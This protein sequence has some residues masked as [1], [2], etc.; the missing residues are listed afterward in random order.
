MRRSYFDLSKEWADPGHNQ[1]V[2]LCPRL[3]LHNKYKFYF[4]FTLPFYWFSAIQLLSIIQLLRCIGLFCQ[5]FSKVILDSTHSWHGKVFICN[6]KTICNAILMCVGLHKIILTL[7]FN[8]IHILGLGCMKL[9][10]GG[11]KGS[12]KKNASIYLTHLVTQK[13]AWHVIGLVRSNYQRARNCSYQSSSWG[14]LE[15]RNY[16]LH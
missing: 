9:V 6:V 5:F 1:L 14:V 4:V 3:S 11:Q 12:W 2:D 10:N 15:L 16:S 8:N 13:K 7:L